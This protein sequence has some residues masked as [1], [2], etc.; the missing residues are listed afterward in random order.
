MTDVLAV[1]AALLILGVAAAIW[2][3]MRRAAKAQRARTNRTS[4]VGRYSDLGFLLGI[5]RPAERPRA[6][7]RESMPD[8]SGAE[9]D[10]RTRR[11]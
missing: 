1:P 10:D 6:E 2:V 9:G 8:A 11:S 5:V 4:F 7:E 3:V